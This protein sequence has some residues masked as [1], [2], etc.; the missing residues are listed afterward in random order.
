[1]ICQS[2]MENEWKKTERESSFQLLAQGSL[3]IQYFLRN[4]PGFFFSKKTIVLGHPDEYSYLVE[5][6]EL[7][8]KSHQSWE[9]ESGLKTL[10]YFILFILFY[11]DNT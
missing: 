9:T 5:Q 10:R 3:A 7:F 8:T 4:K 6:V 1:M 2:H 11:C